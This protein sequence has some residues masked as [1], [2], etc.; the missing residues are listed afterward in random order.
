ML[1]RPEVLTGT[2]IKKLTSCGNLYTTVNYA[3]GRTNGDDPIEIIPRLGKPGGCTA[4]LLGTIGRL[5]SLALQY[6]APAREVRMQMVGVTCHAAD[7]MHPCCVQAVANTL[8]DLNG[9]GEDNN[10]P[11]KTKDNNLPTKTDEPLSSANGAMD[12]QEGIS[13]A[14]TCPECSSPLVMSEGCSVCHSCG[15]SAC[16]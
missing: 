12:V 14:G 16:G 3:N 10:L 8:S 1:R 6:G 9:K 4:A 7:I 11:P 5:A 13:N 15:Y 2:T